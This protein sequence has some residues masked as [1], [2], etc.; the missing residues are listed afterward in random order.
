MKK[1]MSALLCFLLLGQSVPLQAAAASKVLLLYSA[2]SEE[3]MAQVRILDSLLGHFAGDI[4]VVSDEAFTPQ[5]AAGYT[6]VFYA[7]LKRRKLPPAAAAYLNSFSGPLLAMG[8]NTEQLQRFSFVT[9]GEDINASGIFPPDAKQP[10]PIVHAD[11]EASSYALFQTSAAPSASVILYANRLEDGQPVP[12]LL[13]DGQ[14]YYFASDKIDNPYGQV[15]GE[16]MF[17]LFKTKPAS[18]HNAYLRLEDIRPGSDP[19]VLRQI[20]DYLKDE[21]IPYIMSV[22]PVNMDTGQHM[23]DVPELVDVLQY[24]QK[25]GGSIVLHGYSHQYRPDEK[26]GEGFE[27]WD[28]LR[29][30]PIFQEA[31]LNSKRKTRADFADEAAYKA[32]IQA[33]RT[34]EEN[35]IRKRIEHGVQELTVHKLYPLAF[36]APHYTMSQTGYQVASEY[37]STYV[38]RVQISDE[39]WTHSYVPS[40]ET[41]PSFLHGMRLLPETIGFYDM[42][43]VQEGKDPIRDMLS[44]AKEQAQFSDSYIAGF[45]HPALGV[46]HL[47]VLIKELKKVP[48]LHWIDLQK[49]PNTVKIPNLKIHTDANGIHVQDDTPLSVY[50]VKE[51]LGH[52]QS[53]TLLVILWISGTA[54]LLFL[55]NIGYLIW[56]RKEQLHG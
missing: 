56:K 48:H 35:Y 45:Y 7:G 12:I 13:Q 20:A 4:A 37:F 8:Y 38:G 1:F 47:R 40:Y 23:A 28:V 33:G 3:D 29:N 6:H 30:S 9:I 5:T 11:G 42:A 49:Q 18:G 24:M 31:D 16:A 14:S 21:H 54:V 53:D 32:Y 55:L 50:K 34:F 26:T 46:A 25:N 52:A 22:I 51:M 15:L 10:L 19:A 39:T 41:R 43:M 44:H 36:E 2:D 17:P 27:F